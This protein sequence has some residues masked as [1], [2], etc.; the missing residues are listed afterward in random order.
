MTNECPATWTRLHR[1]VGHVRCGYLDTKPRLP[2]HLCGSMA[3]MGESEQ[4]V[5]RHAQSMVEAALTDTRVVL[6]N[7][8][9]QAGKMNP[10]RGGCGNC[11]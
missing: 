8:A 1:L 11:G 5:P 2:G 4:L 9:R 7:G 10:G 6:V 3:P